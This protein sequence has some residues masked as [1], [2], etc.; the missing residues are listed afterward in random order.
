MPKKESFLHQLQFVMLLKSLVP[1]QVNLARELMDVLG[2]SQDGAYRRLRC[3]TAFSLDEAVKI[4]LH[5]SIPLEALNNE[6]PDVVTF[7]FY[8]LDHQVDRFKGYLE[9]LVAQLQLFRKHQMANIHYAAEDV[10]MF[11]HFGWPELGAFK[12]LYWMKSILNIPELD[13]TRF[14][15]QLEEWINPE[16]MQQLYQGY[17]MVPGTEIWSDETI[18]STLQQIRFYW[19]AGF[20][21]HTDSVMIIL[22]QLVEMIKR[23][24]R[25]AETGQ[26]IGFD[27]ASTGAPFSMY[28]CDLM[29][30]NN[31]IY[32]ETDASAVS[33]IGYNTFNSVMTRNEA[34]NKQHRMWMENL[35]RKSIQIS[36]MAEKIRNQFIK[37][38]LRKI[39]ALRTMIRNDIQE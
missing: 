3:E 35:S 1:G 21:E 7:H 39:E 38:Q 10:P 11:Y 32:V 15:Y 9:G 8:Q 26:R 18:E 22:D 12:I 23:I 31:S 2:V 20:F 16:V 25:Q 5:Y 37:S 4:C 36:G 13:Q 14:P 28:L 33:F 34:F 24:A 17:A 19:D 6:V 30:G 27:G 29:I